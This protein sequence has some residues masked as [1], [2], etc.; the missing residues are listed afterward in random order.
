MGFTETEAKIFE[1]SKNIDIAKTNLDKLFAK[2]MDGLIGIALY[3]TLKSSDNPNLR[4]YASEMENATGDYLAKLIRASLHQIS[5][6]PAAEKQK[7]FESFKSNI[8][9][10]IR[11]VMQEAD[12]RY[13]VIS[14]I[15]QA[16]VN[17]RSIPATNALKNMELNIDGILLNGR[18][19]QELYSRGFD[20]SIN[21]PGRTGIFNRPEINFKIPP[22]LLRGA[23][24]EE[25][26]LLLNA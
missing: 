23:N 18:V 14:D 13:G 15:I 1:V 2:E 5:R 10:V 17:P 11:E 22:S 19:I 12:K 20:G 26:D 21:L 24:T 8:E 4:Y 9:G 16:Y 7:F 25:K 6:L 3:R